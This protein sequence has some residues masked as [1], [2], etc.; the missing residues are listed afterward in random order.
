MGVAT[1]N[2][3]GFRKALGDAVVLSVDQIMAPIERIHKTHYLAE[4]KSAYIPV[5][6]GI[7]M[8]GGTGG[9]RI[10]T[11]SASNTLSEVTLTPAAYYAS[12]DVAKQ[13]ILDNPFYFEHVAEEM[14]KAVHKQVMALA[15]AAYDDFTP[16]ASGAMTVSYLNTAATTLATSGIPR[17]YVAVMNPAQMGDLIADL[18]SNY[19]ATVIA[20][21]SFSNGVLRNIN[22][23]ECWEDSNVDLSSGY[24]R[25]FI[26]TRDAVQIAFRGV[27]QV[28]VRDIDPIN[29]EV[30][31]A[32]WIAVGAISTARGLW[33]KNVDS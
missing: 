24:R 5:G 26:G 20:S 2:L 33:L 13:D 7:S 28:Q 11:G 32:A 21:E 29:V 9:T 18:Q 12:I 15:V 14:A 4:A 3:E 30:S 8:T 19:G 16:T 25:G 10:T 1:A 27:P 17:P 23:V 31:I 6:S 22:G